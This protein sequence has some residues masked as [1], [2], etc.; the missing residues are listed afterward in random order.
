MK[1]TYLLTNDMAEYAYDAL[2]R[3]IRMIDKAANPDATTLYYYS[4]DWQ[5]LAEYDGSNVLRRYFVYGNY[6]DEPLVMNDTTDDFYVS[7]RST[8][9]EQNVRA[10]GV[11]CISCQ[12]G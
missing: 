5:V 10:G 2:G 3:R 1:I 6:V 8:A 11:L 4:P 9:C 12:A 7:F